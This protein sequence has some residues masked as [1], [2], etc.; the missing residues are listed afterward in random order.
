M[1]SKLIWFTESEFFEASGTIL[2]N[3][4]FDIYSIYVIYQES[5]VLNIGLKE[6]FEMY[7]SEENRLER[8]YKIPR[9]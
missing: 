9:T 5:K 2:L 3:I 6:C 1:Q 8:I 4:I 7:N